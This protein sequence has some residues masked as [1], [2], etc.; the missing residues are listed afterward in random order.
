[1]ADAIRFLLNGEKR[2]LRDVAPFTT[3]L[4]YLR[5]VEHLTGT[6]EG[7]AE[8]DCGAC[9]VVVGEAVNG[10]MR[11]RAANSCILLL[12]R[13]D[14]KYLLTV[15][16]V[17]NPDGTLHPVQQAMVDMHGT[18]CGF[19]SPGFIMSLFTLYH[20]EGDKPATDE[21]IFDI[22]S[23]NLCRCT[24]YRPILDVA[25]KIACGKKTVLRKMNP[26]SSKL[27]KP[28]KEQSAWSTNI[29]RRNISRPGHYPR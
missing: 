7:C 26:K 15:E 19:C 20:W 11:W 2:E 13:I 18:Q 5:T 16:G 25:R 28:C 14:G 24:G 12:G 3:V 21:D 8:G 6:K 22:L 17:K 1:M 29:I 9:T 27:W 10:K 23:G 4:Q